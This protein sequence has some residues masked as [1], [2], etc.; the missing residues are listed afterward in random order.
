MRA[1]D[2]PYM[3]EEWKPAI[4]M[5]RTFSEKFAKNPTD[6]NLQLKK[7]WRNI[8]SKLRRQSLKY[9]WKKKTEEMNHD[10]R[11]SFMVFKPFLYRFQS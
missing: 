9:Y 6:E 1:K 11:Q 8:A 4:R 10:P 7:S 2:V 3:T 5:K